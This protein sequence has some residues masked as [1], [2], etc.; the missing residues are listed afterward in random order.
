MKQEYLNLR[1]EIQT[2]LSTQRNFSTFSIT[3]IITIIGFAVSMDN[4]PPEFYLIPYILLLLVAAKIRNL[5]NNTALLVGY[6]IAR[7]EEKEGFYWETCLN[8]YRKNK[9]RINSD[10]TQKRTIMARFLIIIDRISERLETQEFTFMAV[11]C[12]GLFCYEAFLNVTYETNIFICAW[13]IFAVIICVL[14]IVV[15]YRCSNEYWNMDDELINKNKNIWKEIIWDSDN[16]QDNNLETHMAHRKKETSKKKKRFMSEYKYWWVICVYL[17][18]PIILIWLIDQLFSNKFNDLMQGPKIEE[19]QF[20]NSPYAIENIISPFGKSLHLILA[21]IFSYILLRVIQKILIKKRIFFMKTK[22]VLEFIEIFSILVAVIIAVYGK[23]E[24]FHPA[25]YGY[26][27]NTLKETLLQENELMFLPLET[28][29]VSTG[30]S[31]PQGNFLYNIT[32][33]LSRLFF[34]LSDNLEII[35]AIIGAVI[36]PLKK[37]SDEIEKIN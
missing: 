1:E 22:K 3:A 20:V 31:T 4:P 14:C 27:V 12:L 7:L 34:V 24:S 29:L 30:L 26:S 21:F 32:L 6:M 35:I 8:K 19:I 18:L 33:K 9:S 25:E 28:D 36:I 16:K 10:I 23:M 37:Y 13:R 11:I 17:S 15:I 5:R 2:N